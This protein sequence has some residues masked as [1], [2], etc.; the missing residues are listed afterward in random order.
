MISESAILRI[1]EI[2]GEDVRGLLGKPALWSQ[3]SQ[4]A[5]S[6]LAIFFRRRKANSKGLV[7]FGDVQ[8]DD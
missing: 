7:F 2:D 3:S 4:I 1:G 8:F 5:R 6:E